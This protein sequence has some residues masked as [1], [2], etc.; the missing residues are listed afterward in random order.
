MYA[1]HSKAY[2]YMEN[3]MCH[4]HNGSLPIEMWKCEHGTY[5]LAV[6]NLTLRLS[7]GQLQT[8]TEF[9][10]SARAKEG[11]GTGRPWD[12]GGGELWGAN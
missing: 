2:H 8:L 6:G 4:Q 1:Y 9:L 12:L 5:H 10:L 11:S 3:R 7:E